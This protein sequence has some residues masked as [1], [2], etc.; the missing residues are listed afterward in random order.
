MN[1]IYLDSRGNEIT[2][3]E[4]DMIQWKDNFLY[5]NSFWEKTYDLKYTFIIVKHIPFEEWEN[6]ETIQ[7]L[8][9]KENES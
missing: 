7:R 6:N 4:K 2:E 5:G 9:N 8:F 1:E 3:H